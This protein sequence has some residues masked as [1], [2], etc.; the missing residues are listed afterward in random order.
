MYMYPTVTGRSNCSPVRPSCSVVWPDVG[1]SA[2][3]RRLLISSSLAPSNTGV[4][5]GTPFFR[6]LASSMI[7]G[8]VID[9]M[10]SF[11][12]PVSL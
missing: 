7:S 2:S 11:W 5:I 8:S 12:P 3:A 9:L 4:A 1:R 10:S 6:L